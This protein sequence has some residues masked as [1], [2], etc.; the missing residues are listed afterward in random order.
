MSKLAMFSALGM[1]LTGALPAAAQ[2]WTP[3]GPVTLAGNVTVQEPS[4]TLNCRI[5][6]TGAISTSGTFRLNTLALQPGSSPLCPAILLSGNP[7]QVISSTDGII[8][9]NLQWTGITANCVGNMTAAYNS[10]SG[11]ITFNLYSSIP[12]TSGPGFCR[13]QGPAW[14]TPVAHP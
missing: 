10:N 7:L 4:L 3:P 13:L 12:A 5:V 6:G 1:M 2:S 14:F 9:T 11:F 8:F